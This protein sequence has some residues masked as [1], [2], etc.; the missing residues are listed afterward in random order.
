[1]REHAVRLDGLGTTIFA[2]MSALAVATGSVNLG[3]G[4]P[5]TDG[6]DSLLED[7]IAAIRAGANQYPPARGIPALR[8]AIVD[9]QKRFY[10]LSYDPDTQVLVTT[11]ATEA[12]AAALLALV[13]PGDEV[14]AL[15]P[16]YDSYAAG[17][18]FAGGRRV[19]VTLRAPDYRLDLDEL[20][21]AVTPRTKVLLINSPHNPTGTVLT[22][23]EL[24]GICAVAIEHDLVVI[25]DEVYEHLVYDGRQHTPLASYDGMAERTVSI[26]SAGKTFSVTGWKIGWVTG[27]PSVVTAVTTAKQFLTFTSGAPFQPAVANALA[28]GN[29]YF[30]AL[31]ADLQSRRDLL[32]DGLAALGFEVHRPAGTYFVT[33]DIRPLGHTDGI[34]FCRMLPERAGV[35]AI[36]HQVFYDNPAPGRPLVRWAFCKQPQ[37]LQEA[38]TRLQTL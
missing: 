9:H 16:Y 7:A 27:A 1:M 3:Q 15:E 14:I 30:D 4:F 37:V 2:E 22:D 17:I 24:R 32:C 10:D 28:L 11:G 6:P 31:R 13:E 23:D 8:Q 25:T 34:A 20:R 21:A 38:L 36:P 26:S 18:A 5:D 19:P 12:V 29:E 35:V 33:T